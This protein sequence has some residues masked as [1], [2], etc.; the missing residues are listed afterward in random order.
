MNS[1]ELTLIGLPYQFGRRDDGGGYRMARGP[2]VLLAADAVPSELTSSGADAPVVTWLDHLDDAAPWD[3][4][5]YPLSPGD[6]MVRQLV[7]NRGLAAAVQQEKAADR[8]PVVIAGGC[9]SSIGVV[10]GLDDPEVGLI[11]FD[12]HADAETPETSPDGLFEGMPVSVIAGRCW[13]RWR[14]NIP[15][16]R[17]IPEE[18][19]M[20]VGLHD[21]AFEEDLPAVQRGI[22]RVVG[23]EEMNESGFQ[24]AFE[25]ALRELAGRI[26]KVYVHIDTDVLD[27]GTVRANKHAAEG[28][29]TPDELEWAVSRI[30][31]AMS[32]EAVSFSSFDT[33]VDE[34]APAVLVPLIARIARLCAAS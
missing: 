9:N 7:Q 17:V 22:G 21:L 30:A 18:W 26:G 13:R 24:A 10:A 19:I 5:S 8:L 29:P 28:G 33:S 31:Q 15:G 16:F 6:Q 32:I 12:A 3:G 4:R 11:W 25:D 2:E 14:E 34:D 20:Q 27:A 23:P 1:R